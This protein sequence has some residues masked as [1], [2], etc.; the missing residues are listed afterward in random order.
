MS[1]RRYAG[2]ALILLALACG[3]PKGDRGSVDTVMVFS[4]A[5]PSSPQDSGR[6]PSSEVL[7]KTIGSYYGKLITADSAAKVIVDYLETNQSLN[8]NFD[9]ELTNA[10]TREQRRRAH[11]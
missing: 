8:A 1:L 9:E 4:A 2:C 10:I 3:H 7:R 5:P 11:R 6:G